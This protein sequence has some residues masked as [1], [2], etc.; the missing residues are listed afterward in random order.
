[1]TS[2]FD[3]STF[4]ELKESLRIIEEKLDEENEE[5]FEVIDYDDTIEEVPLESNFEEADETTSQPLVDIAENEKINKNLATAR[6]IFQCDCG[7]NFSSNQRLRNHVRVTHEFIPESELYSCLSC[8][9]KFKIREY[10]D[11]H[12]RNQHTKNPIKQRQKNPC[13][14]CGKLLSSVTALKNHKER[15]DLE[16]Q[17]KSDIKQFVCDFC[18]QTFRKKAYLFNH[19]H[20]V[21]VK[22]K[23]HCSFCSQGF[24]KK[25]QMF[26]HVRQFHTLETPFHCQFDGCSKS[27]SRKKNFTIHQRVHS[28]VRPYKVRSFFF[29]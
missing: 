21:H 29:F 8:D 15:H 11:L 3:H 23:Y 1:M 5:T 19:M 7:R 24:Y 10:L 22:Q 25:Y 16:A 6:Q 20:N 26:D 2:H 18:N 14:I 13:S 17:P 12:V 27:F 9:K 4:D 28:G